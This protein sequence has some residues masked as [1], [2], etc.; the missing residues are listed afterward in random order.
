MKKCMFNYLTSVALCI[1]VGIQIAS[2]ACKYPGS[3]VG[4]SCSAGC[5]VYW[6][7]TPA[8]GI[9]HGSGSPNECVSDGVTAGIKEVWVGGSCS[10]VICSGGTLLTSDFALCIKKKVGGPCGGA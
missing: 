5:A 7:F 8:N 6:V 9:C 2:A 3:E 10:G 1:G 4:P